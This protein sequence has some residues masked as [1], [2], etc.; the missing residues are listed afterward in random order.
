MNKAHDVDSLVKNV[1]DALVQGVNVVKTFKAV[2]EFAGEG[3]EEKDDHRTAQLKRAMDSLLQTQ[4]R[5]AAHKRVLN[6]IASE[7]NS[8][9]AGTLEPDELSK[10][11]QHDCTNAADADASRADGSRNHKYQ[12]FLEEAGLKKADDVDDEVQMTQATFDPHCQLTKAVFENPMRSTPCFQRGS[13]R[14]VFSKDAIH[15][16]IQ[17]GRGGARCPTVGCP[18]GGNITAGDLKACK[19]TERKVKRWLQADARERMRRDRE[20]DVID[21]EVEDADDGAMDCTQID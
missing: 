3:D 9:S 15:S 18:Y 21:D 5:Y 20:A 12:E 11:V 6:A 1:D 19:D 13:S 4:A 2:K 7:L 17:Q 14:C 8:P 16:L 10:R